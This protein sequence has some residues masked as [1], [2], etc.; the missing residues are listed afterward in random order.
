MPL[1]TSLPEKTA[2]TPS[3]SKLVI[4]RLEEIPVTEEGNSPVKEEAVVKKEWREKELG[5]KAKRVEKFKKLIQTGTSSRGSKSP[6]KAS[7]KVK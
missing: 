7:T 6:P 4:E 5:R 3:R 1:D 2:K